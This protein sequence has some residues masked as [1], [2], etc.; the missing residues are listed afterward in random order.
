MDFKI[1]VEYV[2]GEAQFLLG[3]LFKQNEYQYF[4]RLH[5]DLDQVIVWKTN[6]PDGRIVECRFD[7][8]WPNKWR[9]SRFRDDKLT[10]NHISVYQKILK[11]IADNVTKDT[12]IFFDQAY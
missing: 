11:S 12:V 1:S 2:N 7:N 8:E 6:P 4:G 5:L 3:I 9:F 10:A